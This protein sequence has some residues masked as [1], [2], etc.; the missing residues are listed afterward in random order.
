MPR[1]AAKK[2]GKPT[3]LTPEIQRKACD[4]IRN[5]SSRADAAILAGVPR[6]TLQTW[7]AY[8]REGKEPFRGFLDAMDVAEAECKKKCLAE[9]DRAGAKVKH[10]DGREVTF[11]PLWQRVAWKLERRWP[12]EWGRQVEVAAEEAS[13]SIRV[14]FDIPNRD[15]GGA[16]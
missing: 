3:R 13:E 1:P 15:E 9:I 5:G 6:S 11:S 14:T 4:E 16:T 2:A 12:K 7:L 10:P 8:G